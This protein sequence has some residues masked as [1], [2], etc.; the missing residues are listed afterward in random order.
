MNV[1]HHSAFQIIALPILDRIRDDQ[2]AQK[3]D[4]RLESLKM[5]CHV[6]PD[7]P[8][9]DDQERRHEERNLHRRAD[10]HAHGEIHLVLDGH[11]DGCDVLRGISDDREEYQAHERLGDVC[12]LDERVY[13][14]DEIL[15]A[16]GHRDS[17]D[18]EHAGCLPRA[19]LRLL[20]FA[21]ATAF[22]GL[23]LGVEERGVGAQLEDEVEHVEDEQDDG[24]AAG[25]EEDVC[26]GILVGFCEAGVD[27]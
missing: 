6:L 26:F 10:R 2:D 3:E 21:A 16:H 25:E 5:E 12:G 7:D 22:A 4:D 13:A 23:G 27:L 11:D 9:Q 17:D 20:F 19:Q 1:T 14:A 18:D 24:S 8:A 15:G